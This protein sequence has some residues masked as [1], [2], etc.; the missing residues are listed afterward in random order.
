MFEYIIQPEASAATEDGAKKTNV[1][2]KEEQVSRI[3]GFSK[4]TP[5]KHK[6]DSIAIRD[7]TVV[8]ALPPNMVLGN[9]QR[10][11][12]RKEKGDRRRAVEP[13]VWVLPQLR[14]CRF[15][16]SLLSTALLL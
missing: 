10:V 7:S 12:R 4:A 13:H 14:L 3:S 2:R 15:F 8:V 11:E 6:S 16:Y 1:P 9:D 5:D